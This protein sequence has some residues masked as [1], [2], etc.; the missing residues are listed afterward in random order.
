[1][2]YKDYYNT[3]GVSRQATDEEII[4]LAKCEWGGDYPADDVARFCDEQPGVSK[5]FEW[6][7]DSEIGFECHVDKAAA[8]K[9]L[10]ENKPALAAKIEV[11]Q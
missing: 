9:W 5:V 10:R 6:A 4:E 3:L 2:E 11:E 1:M 7:E 8:M